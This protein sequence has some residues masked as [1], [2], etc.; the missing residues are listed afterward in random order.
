MSAK[1]IRTSPNN[2]IAPQGPVHVADFDVESTRFPTQKNPPEICLQVFCTELMDVTY[3][4]AEFMRF[5]M[6]FFGA[7]DLGY[8]H[9]SCICS[10]SAANLQLRIY[11]QISAH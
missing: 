5:C 8:V 2:T 1:V 11:S 10:Y 3:F 7:A 9:T 4:R 6:R